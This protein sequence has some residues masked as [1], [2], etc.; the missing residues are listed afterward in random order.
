MAWSDDAARNRDVWT[1]SNAE[2]TD[3]QAREV[4]AAPEITWGMWG[5]REA[6]LQIFGDV[7]G[8]DAVELGCGTAYMSAWLASSPSTSRRMVSSSRRAV[9]KL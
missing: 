1:R 6:E 4:W 8:L 2:Y 5:A 7:A 9:T 3:A